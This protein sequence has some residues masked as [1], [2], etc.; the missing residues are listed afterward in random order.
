M[1]VRTRPSRACTNNSY[2]YAGFFDTDS[3]GSDFEEFSDIE[4]SED[5]DETY[6]ATN[7]RHEQFDSQQGKDAWVGRR[8]VKT[9]GDYGDFEGI[10][11]GVDDDANKP[12][13]R[14]FLVHYFDD[15]DD[16]EEMWPEELVRFV[17]I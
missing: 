12:G 5:D 13:Y 1:Q 9:F 11:Y 17:Q 10:V 4:V 3:E 2:Q 15:P 14:L 8:I 16:G 7:E 6:D